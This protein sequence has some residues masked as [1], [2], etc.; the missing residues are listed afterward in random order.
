MVKK[1][2]AE[3]DRWPVPSDWNEDADGYLCYLICVPNSRTWRGI[4]DGLI[5]SLANGRR[6]NRFSGTITDAQ[7]VAREIFENMCAVRCDDLLAA[8]Q[9]IC[10]AQTIA[11]TQAAGAATAIE[12]QLNS[13]DVSFGPDEQFDTAEQYFNAK[14]S[15]ANGIYDT[16]LNTVTW[17]KSNN[18]D[19]LAGLFGAVTTALVGAMILAGPVGWAT[20]LALTVVGAI[21][22]YLVSIPVNFDDLQDAIDEQHEACVLALYNAS[23]ALAAENNFIEALEAAPTSITAAESGLIALMLTSDATNQLF[24]PRSDVAVYNSPNPIDC[25][26]AILAIWTYPEDEEGWDF[27]DDSAGASSASGEYDAN[28]KGLEVTMTSAGGS[29]RPITR[30]TWFKTGLA[31]AFPAGSTC[32]IDYSETSD[33]ITGSYTIRVIYSDASE[34]SKNAEAGIGAGT[35]IMSMPAAKTISEIEISLGRTTSQARTYS[36]ILEEVRIVSS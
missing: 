7:S 14:C 9:C 15:V 24:A 26:A 28:E 2:K 17:L 3:S 11:A 19:M 23:D 16:L 12:Q 31:I 21:A 22:S 36:R 6:W 30:G 13:G 32:Q 25:G 34:T 35:K 4:F 33:G 27:R 5:S 29:G 1:K 20:V 10:D 18:V 8:L